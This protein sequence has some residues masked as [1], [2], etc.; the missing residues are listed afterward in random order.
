MIK[1]CAEWQYERA[2]YV[3]RIK[4]A[5]KNRISVEGVEKFTEMCYNIM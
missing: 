5:N 2:I 1:W 4:C 3:R